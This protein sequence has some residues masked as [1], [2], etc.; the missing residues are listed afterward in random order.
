MDFMYF[1]TYWATRQV[2]LITLQ[3]L[4]LCLVSNI[5]ET[6][7]GLL[8]YVLKLQEV[9]VEFRKQWL[10]H[11]PFHPHNKSAPSRPSFELPEFTIPWTFREKSSLPPEKSPSNTPSKSLDNGKAHLP[12]EKSP[13][14]TTSKPLDNDKA[15]LLHE[16]SPPSTPSKLWTMTRHL[17]HLRS[18][19]RILRVR[20]WTMTR[21]ISIA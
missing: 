6:A 12:P 17:Y 21:H 9:I 3:R 10:Y 14:N 4:V 16:K 18:H 2:A 20:I 8:N 1:L 15:H 7:I 5:I 11:L 19:L 13:P